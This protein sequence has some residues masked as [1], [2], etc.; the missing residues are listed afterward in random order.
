MI[1]KKTCKK[2]KKNRP[3]YNEDTVYNSVRDK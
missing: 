2:L 3:N 1:C